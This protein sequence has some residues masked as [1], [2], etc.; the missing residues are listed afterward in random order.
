VN[1]NNTRYEDG[2]YYFW[3]LAMQ[4]RDQLPDNI[5]AKQLNPDQ[6]KTLDF[7]HE[8]YALSEVYYAYHF[9]SR[10]MDEPFTSHQSESLFNMA[11]FVLNYTNRNPV[12]KGTP[13]TNHEAFPA[14]TFYSHLQNFPES[15]APTKPPAT[16]TTN[17]SPASSRPNGST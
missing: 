7:F 8:Y 17:S 14:S 10:Y 12:P 1:P 9:V 13:K 16:P 15:S 6:K 3:T 11:L 5:P 4:H 2:A